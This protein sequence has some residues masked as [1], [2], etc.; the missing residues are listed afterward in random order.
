M[1]R[2]FDKI[3]YFSDS[4][5]N[6]KFP[7]ESPTEELRN[8]FPWHKSILFYFKMK[9]RKLRI[10][11]LGIN[12]SIL[13][14]MIKLIAFYLFHFHFARVVDCGLW[15]IFLVYSM[16]FG[17]FWFRFSLVLITRKRDETFCSIVQFLIT[18]L[19][20][21]K[22]KKKRSKKSWRENEKGKEL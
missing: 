18:K 10:R 13:N 7:T 4:L 9:E 6:E 15:S 22:K 14:I 21:A 5:L 16:V 11:V 1:R 12:T 19:F 2:Y 20:S 17:L 8:K 3:G